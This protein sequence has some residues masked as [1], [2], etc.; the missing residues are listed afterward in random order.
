[1]SIKE[2]LY[3]PAVVFFLIT[4]VISA[5][6]LFLSRYSVKGKKSKRTLDS[7]AC[8]QQ[9][10]KE[11]VNPDYSQFFTFAFVFTVMHVLSMVIATA[12]EKMTAMPILYI[13]A[14]VYVL[15]IVL[16]R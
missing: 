8:G 4:A 11:Y 9:G 10:F 15:V 12:P 5:F 2:V 3:S 6:A 13:L 1:M 16:K 7:Y 14:G